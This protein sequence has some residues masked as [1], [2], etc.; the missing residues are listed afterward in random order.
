MAAVRRQLAATANSPLQ[1][2]NLGCRPTTHA[3][4]AAAG[5][6]LLLCVAAGPAAAG[7]AEWK[8]LHDQAGRHLERGSLE[9]AELFA[10]EALKEAESTLG[11][12]HRATEHSLSTLSM[13]LRLRGKPEEALPVAQRLVALRTRQYGADDATT[14]IA[15]HNQ[16]EILIT[17]NRLAEAGK[18]Q[19]NALAVFEKTYGAKHANTGAALHNMGAILLKQEKYRDAEK[20]LRR[21]LAVKE[22]ALKPGHLSIAHTLDNLS[23]ALDAQGRQ[24]EAEKYKRRAD[25][26]RRKAG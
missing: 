22:Q 7:E 6:L 4:S 2:A 24:N 21:A 16:A 19:G 18:L 5:F 15:L 10:R 26:I 9:Q 11:P 25:A 14:A 23:A 8:L 20:Y 1:T 12:E 13:A 17:Q 3:F